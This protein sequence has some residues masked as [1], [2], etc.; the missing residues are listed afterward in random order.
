MAL[1]RRQ[2]RHLYSL[3]PAQRFAFVKDS[4]TGMVG[5]QQGV[6]IGATTDNGVRIEMYVAGERHTETTVWSGMVYVLPLDD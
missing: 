2:M 3:A 4:S 5:V 6:V 1:L